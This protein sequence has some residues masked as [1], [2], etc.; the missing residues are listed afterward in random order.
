MKRHLAV[1]VD[2]GVNLVRQQ[3]N[4]ETNIVTKDAYKLNWPHALSGQERAV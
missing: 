4:K 2:D 1:R 3:T